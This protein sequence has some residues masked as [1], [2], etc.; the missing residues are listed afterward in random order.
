MKKQTEKAQPTRKQRNIKEKRYL[1]ADRLDD[2]LLEEGRGAAAKLAAELNVEPQAISNYRR[3]I[4]D[5]T[6]DNLIKIAEHYHVSVDWL[7]GRLPKENR[8]TNADVRSVSDYTGLSS[9]AVETLHYW[10]T[11]KDTVT[12]N[13]DY[14][15]ETGTMF[16]QSKEWVK[17]LSTLIETDAG[18]KYGDMKEAFLLISSLYEIVNYNCDR[19]VLYTTKE[20]PGSTYR[21][22]DLIGDYADGDL[23]LADNNGVKKITVDILKKA[24]WDDFT[25]RVN[26]LAERQKRVAEKPERDGENDGKH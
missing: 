1:A 26:L 12:V 25:Q 4:A 22:F 17:F 3:G 10:H 15:Y 21:D 8:S 16:P 11:Q 9:A 5:P 20:I 7:L 13:E 23:F 19:L 18:N 6:M 2:L 14:S 24:L